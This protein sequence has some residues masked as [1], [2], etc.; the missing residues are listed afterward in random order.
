MNLE[1]LE[2]RVVVVFNLHIFEWTQCLLCSHNH[3]QCDNFSILRFLQFIGNGTIGFVKS[4]DVIPDYLSN[5]ELVNHIWDLTNQ[6]SPV[7]RGIWDGLLLLP[8]LQYSWNLCGP[9]MPSLQDH[10]SFCLAWC[11][12]CESLLL[13]QCHQTDGLA[14]VIW[15]SPV[16][17]CV[18]FTLCCLS[19]VLL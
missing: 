3:F 15:W 6:V 14:D 2:C 12:N 17:L 16:L 7:L 8:D 1:S 10:A 18:T 4:S 5:S 13:T 11:C 9:C 19:Y